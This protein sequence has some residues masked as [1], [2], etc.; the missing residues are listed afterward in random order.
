[1]SWGVRSH[2]GTYYEDESWA[3]R[4]PLFA[5]DCV[6]IALIVWVGRFMISF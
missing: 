6:G 3:R 2:A 1:M 4:A 5:P